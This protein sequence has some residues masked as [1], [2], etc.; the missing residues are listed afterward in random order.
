MSTLDEREIIARR[1]LKQAEWCRKLGSPPYSRLLQDAAADVRSQGACWA[2]LQ[3]HHDDPPGSALALRFLGAVHRLV[4]EGNA[5]ELAACYPS[6]GGNTG[7][8]DLWP[9][10]LRTVRQYT[11]R[12]RV[13][14][15]NPVQTN[16]VGRCAALLGGFLETARRTG[17]PLRLLEIGASAGLILRWDQYFYQADDG[18]WGNPHS[19]VRISAAFENAHPDFG[20]TVNVAERRGCDTSPIDPTT[21]EGELTLKSYVW[22]DQVERFRRLSAAIEI[23]TCVPARLEEANAAEWIEAALAQPAHGT[24]TVVYHS[25]VWQYLSPGDRA[26]IEQ[27]IKAAGKAA[28]LASPLAWLRF[29]PGADAAEVRLRLW[30]GSQDVE[31]RLLARAGFHGRP[32]EWLG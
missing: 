3:G 24:A 13:L 27:A 8:A 12:L 5:P 4:L 30:P 15:D 20:V 17:L 19:N 22:A 31:D 29:E 26:R 28:T 18:A 25:I 16:E 7:S 1:L 32:V 14:I 11:P 21:K 10:F 2:V 6:V 9:S 23:A